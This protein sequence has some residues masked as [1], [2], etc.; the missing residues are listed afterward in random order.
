LWQALSQ[1]WP[2]YFIEG[3]LLGTFM[4][5]ACIAVAA[6]E[7]PGSSVRR[8]I[9]SGTL[10]RSIIG[11]LMGLT[12]VALIYSPWGQRSGAHMNPGIT[13]TFLALGKARVWDAVFYIVAQFAGGI[14]G[15]LV[16]CGILGKAIRHHSVN[17]AVTSPGRRGVRPAFMAELIIAF[18]MMGMVLISTNHIETAPFTG[19][20]AGLLVA[21]YIAIEAPL[22]G[23]S[24]NPARSLASAVPARQYRAL[25]IYFTA[26]PL[27]MLS[28]AGLYLL[29][30]GA[31]HIFC[32]K[33]DHRGGQRCI[34][35]CREGEM[36][37][38]LSH[39][40]GIQVGR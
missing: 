21:L 9:R 19:L 4:L 3:A 1:H 32:A 7:H 26:P 22:S 8:A 17:F 25:W 34:F 40:G 20:F 31:D 14:T 36:H 37:G 28:A 23:M 2:E 24:I 5:A 13:L 16:A 12:A 10:R 11:L 27:G 38:N 33:F 30:S 18:V 15:V 6:L 35:N 39:G 29:T